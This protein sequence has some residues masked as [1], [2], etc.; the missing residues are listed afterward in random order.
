M[1][2]EKIKS[3]AGAGQAQVAVVDFYEAGEKKMFLAFAS[4]K[5]LK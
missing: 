5:I 3:I 1:D 4:L 2:V